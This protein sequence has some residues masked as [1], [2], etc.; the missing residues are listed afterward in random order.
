MKI[1]KVYTTILIAIVTIGM[2]SISGCKDNGPSALDVRT[3][4]L[5]ASGW[6]VNA[7]TIDGVDR[8]AQHASMTLTFS[9]SEYTTTNGGFVW[10]AS[11][12]WAFAGADATIITRSDGVEIT[13]VELTDASLK[14]SFAWTGTYQQGRVSSLRGNHI[15]S[16]VK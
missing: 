10:P 3:K 11:G 12:T 5:T 16:F 7:V 8:T 6:K 2:L 4:A 14:L 13:V 1:T 15:F 9:A